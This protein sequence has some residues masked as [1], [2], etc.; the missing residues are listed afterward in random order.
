MYGGTKT[1][2]ERLI[3]DAAK[4]KDEQKKL[5]VAV[6]EGDMS[7]GNIVNAISVM[8][9]HLGIAGTTA[10]EAKNTITG[11]IN[12]MKAAFDN[13]LNGSGSPEQL[14]KTITDVFRNVSEALI[15]L[16]PSILSGVTQLIQ[17]L[18]PQV[19]QLLITIIPQLLNAIFQM[20]TALNGMLVNK[21]ASDTSTL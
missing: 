16:A 3:A 6:D 14:A 20:L 1:E 19:T 5:N 9:E 11:S 8:Q 4:M 7:F 18:I 12:S 10:D 17:T 21:R 2:M 15:E 13:F